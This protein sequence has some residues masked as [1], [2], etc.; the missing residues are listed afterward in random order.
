[1]D[2]LIASL[3]YASGMRI[4]ECLQ[5]RV[6][7][8]GFDDLIIRVYRGKGQKDR[9]TVLDKSLVPVLKEHLDGVRTLFDED[10]LHDPRLRWGDYHVFPDETLKVMAGSRH[11]LR[12]PLH[13]NRFA[14]ALADA[15]GRAGI[16][17]PV[18]PH[19]LRHSF[20]T[21][22]LELGNDIRKVQ[23]LL[24]HA[25]VSTTMLYTHPK[26]RSGR[27]WASLLGRFRGKAD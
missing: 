7:D 12:T 24:G 3:L 2:L 15:A 23:E 4:S 6:Q 21:H 25:F 22:M 19:V 20:A 1:V 16:A 11:L 17:T 27:G 13:R 14:R 8:I 26:E 18:T 5:L 10:V 9:V